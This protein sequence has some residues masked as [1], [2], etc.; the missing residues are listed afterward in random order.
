MIDAARLEVVAR[1]ELQW[2]WADLAVAVRS[3]LNGTWS[4]HCE[5]IED[6]IKA[7]TPLVGPTPWE[8]I[9]IPL[10]ETG[11]YQRIHEELGIE[12]QVDMEGVAQHR[13]RLDGTATR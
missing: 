13:A 11:T 5:A 8:Q 12:V 2:L 10:L 4:V 7:L 3:A 1:E 6:R 9:Q